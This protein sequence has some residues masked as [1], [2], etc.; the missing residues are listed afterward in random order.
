MRRSTP[1]PLPLGPGVVSMIQTE[2]SAP[3]PIADAFAPSLSCHSPSTYPA[4]VACGP[5]LTHTKPLRRNTSPL[6][7][8]AQGCPSPPTATRFASPSTPVQPVVV[9]LYVL[10][11]P[12]PDDPP[13]P[14]DHTPG[15]SDRLT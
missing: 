5:P 7:L 15:C 11:E 14:S 6:L 9:E 4:C 1:L 13:V 2:P 12:S 10:T 3:T 8:I